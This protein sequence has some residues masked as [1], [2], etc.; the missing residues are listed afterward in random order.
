MIYLKDANIIFLKP[1]KVAGTSFEIA[2][3][4]FAQ[5]DDIITPITD[6]DEKI[7]NSL[8]FRGPQNYRKSIF[9]WNARDVYRRIKKSEIAA[10]FYNHI[11]AKEAQKLLGKQVFDSAFKITIVR[12]PFDAIISKYFWGNHEGMKQ[13]PLEVWLRK[14][15]SIIRENYAQYFI[16]DDCII[17][18]FIRFESLEED[19]TKLEK[20]KGVN[21]LWDTFKTIN[22]KGKIRPKDATV[23]A[24]LSDKPDVVD[25]IRFFN[26][27]IIDKFDYSF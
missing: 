12:N 17:D 7:R 15:P 14:K 22:A 10:N 24:T 8:N 6:A 5:K 3:T 1:R 26:K 9:E 20:L 27:E 13:E 2:L 23:S 18:H 19:I 25:V 4:K 16:N 21:G 11:T